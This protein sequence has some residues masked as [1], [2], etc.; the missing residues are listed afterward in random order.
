MGKIQKNIP[1]IS[2]DKSFENLEDFRIKIIILFIIRFI[3][4]CDNG[5]KTK[6]DFRR[7][8]TCLIVN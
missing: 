8:F 5:V 6:P 4:L 2:L 1:E 3:N 7:W